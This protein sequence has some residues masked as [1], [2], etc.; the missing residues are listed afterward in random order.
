M[1]RLTK[2]SE[3][4]KPCPHDSEKMCGGNERVGIYELSVLGQ[5]QRLDTTQEG[6]IN[7]INECEKLCSDQQTCHSFQFIYPDD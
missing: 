4:N 7:D 1:D 2:E 6:D 3:C 5:I